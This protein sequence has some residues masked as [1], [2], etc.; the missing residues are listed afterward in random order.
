MHCRHAVESGRG[1]ESRP[2]TGL[3]TVGIEVVKEP[4]EVV[5]DGIDVVVVARGQAP[6]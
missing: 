1:S 2:G 3:V 4:E 6:R 5:Q